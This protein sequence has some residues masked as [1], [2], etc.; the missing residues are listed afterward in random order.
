LLY[1]KEEEEGETLWETWRSIEEEK[2]KKNRKKNFILFYFI[3]KNVYILIFP[4][5]EFK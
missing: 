2:T 5:G 3:L 1:E 4:P